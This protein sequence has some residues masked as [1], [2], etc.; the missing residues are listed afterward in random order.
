[1][2]HKDENNL[3]FDYLNAN[4]HGGYFYYSAENSGEIAGETYTQT[5]YPY[6]NYHQNPFQNVKAT[7]HQYSPVPRNMYSSSETFETGTKGYSRTFSGNDLLA[8]NASISPGR[9]L[10]RFNSDIPS[11]CD[12]GTY[13]PFQGSPLEIANLS[14]V[15]NRPVEDQAQHSEPTYET[16]SL[17]EEPTEVVQS[18]RTYK[19]VLTFPTRSESPGNA[20]E[21]S[22]KTERQE[23]RENEVRRET[24]KEKLLS[25]KLEMPPSFSKATPPSKPGLNNH[26][27]QV[28]INPKKP[29]KINNNLATGNV[30]K[31]NSKNQSEKNWHSAN[32]SVRSV[33][34]QTDLGGIKR[35]NRPSLIDNPSFEF[36]PTDDESVTPI[37]VRT[38]D[39]KKNE[40]T[41]TKVRERDNEKSSRRQSKRNP[42][43]STSATL[44]R[45]YFPKVKRFRNY[46]YCKN[47]LFF[48]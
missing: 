34:S 10:R 18:K 21:A 32:E 38:K 3:D 45:A 42:P 39:L 13:N 31:G 14:L 4:M 25:P 22:K 35:K 43:P 16:E 48:Q 7:E 47:T 8:E 23:T 12:Y 9:C 2:S 46:M 28:N 36:P 29:L 17:H 26:R 41:K 15:E 44:A 30:T 6:S 27:S 37:E 20:N 11:Y 19:D 24:Y 5:P 1:M 40:R 33:R